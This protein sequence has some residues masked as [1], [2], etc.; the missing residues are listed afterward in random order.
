MNRRV[1]PTLRG[2]PEKSPWDNRCDSS[3]TDG[4]HFSRRPFLHIRRRWELFDM[5]NANQIPLILALLRGEA[6]VT[7]L[8][9]VSTGHCDM[10]R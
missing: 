7:L 1:R 4:G 9:P 6:T 5:F 8:G 10:A 2:A 3:Q